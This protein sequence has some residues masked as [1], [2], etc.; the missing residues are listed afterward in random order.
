MFKENEKGY[1]IVCYLEGESFIKVRNIQQKLFELTGSNKCLNSWEPHVTI[2]SGIV[3]SSDKQQ[4]MEESF[5]ELVNKQEKF[6]ITIENFD[7]ISN[8]AGA[9]EGVLT[10][11]VL[12][13]DVKMNE[14]LMN[15]FKD[16]ASLITDKYD[17]WWSRIIDY[18]PHIT[19]AYGDLTEEGY[20]IGMD[21]LKSINFYEEIVISH[22]A[23]VE[24]SENKDIEY[25]RFYFKK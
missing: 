14:R 7:G 20:K 3:V 8:W 5:Q 11:Y 22:I 10:P 15:L 17:T 21:Y 23:L 6:T 19:V 1:Q 9:K 4:E 2:G 25:K 16:T 24:Y 13:I 18:V 12:W